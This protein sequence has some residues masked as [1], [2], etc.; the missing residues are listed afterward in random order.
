MAEKHEPR[1]GCVPFV[2]AAV[3]FGLPLLYFLS[4]GPVYQL[5][6]AGYFSANTYRTMYWPLLQ[7]CR[8]SP[9]F[10]EVWVNY[11]LLCGA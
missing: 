2:I 10:H 1:G 5:A 11:L 7:L 4:S 8:L 6:D 3:I 9:G